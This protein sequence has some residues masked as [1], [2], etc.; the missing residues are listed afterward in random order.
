MDESKLVRISK[1]LS[2]VLRHKPEQI[3]LSLNAQ[4]WADVEELIRKALEAGVILDRPLLREVVEH[5]QKKRFSFSADG[6]EIRANYGHSIPIS[7]GDEYAE[8]PELLYHGTTKRF[9]PS[10]EGEGLGPG[11]RQYVHLVEDKKTAVEVGRRH[12]E[13]VVLVIKA[14]DM[15]EKGFEFFKTESG[16]WLTRNVPAEYIKVEGSKGLKEG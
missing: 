10:I 11:T 13:P 7:L 6:K 4:G 1:F 15:H 9:L 14:Q 16:I 8:P 3:G 2:L 12:G 5:A